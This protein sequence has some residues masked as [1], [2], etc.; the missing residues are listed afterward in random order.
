MEE[1]E[2]TIVPSFIYL[3][4]NMKNATEKIIALIEPKLEE[5]KLFLVEVKVLQN[6]RVQVYIDGEENVTINQCATIS[7]YL[8][9]RLDQ[10]GL[11]P[12]DYTLEVSSPGMSNPLKVPQQFQKRVGRVLDITYKN[13]VKLKVLL[14]SADQ[15]GINVEV[16][17]EK[18]KN[19]K[20]IEEEGV[21]NILRIPYSDI[22]TALLEIKFK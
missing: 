18:K 1:K 4:C 9:E 20:N 2:G 19:K 14:Q 11:V 21:K 7:R 16:Q 10:G 13:N 17:N 12:A 3:T 5:E 15:E 8:Q 6:K 22:Q